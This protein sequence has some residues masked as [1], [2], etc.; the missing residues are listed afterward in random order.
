MFTIKQVADYLGVSDTTIRV[1]WTSEFGDY[2]SDYAKPPKGQERRFTPEDV[3]VLYTVAAMR[4]RGEDYGAVHSVL[5]TGERLEPP[6]G[7]PLDAAPPEP[8]PENTDQQTAVMVSAF[9]A[10]LASYDARV[11]K[12][13]NRLEEALNARL[14]A[15]IRAAQAEKELDLLRTEQTPPAAIDAP[16]MTFWEWWRMGRKK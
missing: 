6:P 15:E 1:N 13:E 4:Q 16:K 10:A 11:N 3:A 7:Q 5:S 9:H 2:L 12:L 8:E 14:S